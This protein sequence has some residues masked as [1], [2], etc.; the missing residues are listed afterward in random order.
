MAWREKLY[1]RRLNRPVDAKTIDAIRGE[2]QRRR[3]E[4]PVDAEL[5]NHPTKQEMT[6]KTKWLSFIVQ[7]HKESLTVDAEL[8]LTAKILA[9][10]EN[11]KVA[12]AFIDSIANDL[13]L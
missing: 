9:T 6:I 13:N 10:A 5:V 2:F 7:F 12:V 4:I 11:R 3:H 1:E 8:S